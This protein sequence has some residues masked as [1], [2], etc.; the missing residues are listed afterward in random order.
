MNQKQLKQ[1]IKPMIKE[2]LAEMLIEMRFDQIVSETISKSLGK[3]NH[4]VQ[5]QVSPV[6]NQP[7]KDPRIEQQLLEKRRK[8]L[9][10]MH[11]PAAQPRV[12]P[13]TEP[14]NILESVLQDTEESGY[15]IEDGNTNPELVSEDTVD[16]LLGGKD[17]SKYL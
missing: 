11:T 7:T 13:K 15:M 6:R 4:L 16:E 12:T 10:A 9:D 1:L 5:E 14:K 17:F 2:V 3:I 8:M